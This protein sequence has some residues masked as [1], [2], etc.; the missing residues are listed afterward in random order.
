MAGLGIFPLLRPGL[1]WDFDL[2]LE[3]VLGALIALIAR[4]PGKPWK[5][6][7]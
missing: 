1:T 2:A 4:L 7:V 6:E 5:G 3:R